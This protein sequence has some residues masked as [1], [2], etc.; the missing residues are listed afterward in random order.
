MTQDVPSDLLF[1]DQIGA[2]PWLFDHNAASPYPNSYIDGWLQHV[3]TYRGALL[4][5]E[6]GFDRLAES[7][8]GF[9]GS[10][11]LPQ[12]FGLTPGWWGDAWHPYPLAQILARD[13]VLFYQHDLAPETFTFDKGTL[14]WNMA[15][16]AMLSYDLVQSSY[17]GGVASDWVNLVAVFQKHVFSRYAG[18]RIT[19]YASLQPEVTQ[20]SFETFTATANWDDNSSYATAG[21]VLPPQGA[22]VK[23]ND[24]TL[25]AGVFT[26]YNGAALS[27]GDHYLVEERKSDQIIVRQPMGAA[28]SLTIRLLPGWTSATRLEA[29]AFDKGDR[30]LGKTAVAV[31]TVAA[32]FTYE[33]QLAGQAV[34]YYKILKPIRAWLP[35]VLK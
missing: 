7:E 18:E 6:L 28:T 20:T 10:V 24:G 3:W 29:W 35:A 26:G 11:L 30:Y 32:T 31:T 15:F 13:K 16:G 17:G 4:M 25:V 8:T 9:H 2:R 14:A 5:T 12:R 22:L 19:D 1:E 33:R 23:K 27:A 21:Y 34:A